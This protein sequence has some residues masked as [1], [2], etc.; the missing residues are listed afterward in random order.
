MGFEL[1]YR[2]ETW[3]EC[4]CQRAV[5]EARKYLRTAPINIALTEAFGGGKTTFA[6]L[7]TK[8]LLCTCEDASLRPC[9]A[10]PN[11]L[12]VAAKWWRTGFGPVGMPGEGI[13]GQN[14]FWVFDCT[15]LLPNE[16]KTLRSE[17][18]QYGRMP[19]AYIFDELHR[20]QVP[21]QELFLKLLEEPL[22]GSTIFCVAKDHIG[23]VTRA[24]LQRLYVLDIGKPEPEELLE[25]IKRIAKAEH[26]VIVDAAAVYELIEECACVPRDVLR[27]LERAAVEGEGLT[28]RSVRRFAASLRLVSKSKESGL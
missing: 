2:P 19:K 9:A 14:W 1:R 27:G 8:E 20:A 22:P 18:A 15:T 10:C 7:M 4:L 25:F 11:C 16:V 12:E 26:I 24:L 13:F 21:T 6:Y 3:A 17:F 28:L 5:V 23:R